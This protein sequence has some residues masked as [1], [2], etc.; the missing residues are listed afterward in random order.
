MKKIICTL[1]LLLIS[2]AA[3][4]H[5]GVRAVSLPAGVSFH[6]QFNIGHWQAP[7][8]LD[9]EASNPSAQVVDAYSILTPIGEFSMTLVCFRWPTAKPETLNLYRSSYAY[10][11]P[12]PCD[13]YSFTQALAV[14]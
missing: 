6:S 14:I 11:S 8:T 10:N 7:V 12:S 13:A 2:I 9:Q 4:A 1:C 5:A 3:M